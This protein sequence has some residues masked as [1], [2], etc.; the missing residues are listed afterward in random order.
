M[1]LT[2]LALLLIAAAMHAVTNT[3][4]KKSKDK[5][6]FGWWQ[7]GFFCVA[8]SP[9]LLFLK[10]VPA[11]GWTFVILSGTLEA[12]YFYSL[13]QAYT[14]G[15]LSV[16]YPIARGSAP[17]FVLIWASLFLNERPTSIGLLGIF[18]VV[19]GLYFI[20]LP[21]IQDWIRPLAGLR[22]PA[23]R[24]ALLTGLLISFYT[25]I[26]K[27]GIVYFS[28]WVY[29]YMI[30]AISWI[31]LGLQW[32]IPERRTALLAEVS[33]DRSLLPVLGASFFGTCG[34]ALVLT[35]MKLT[36]VSYVSPV[37]E[38]SVVMGTWIG[39]RFLGE[40]GGRLR[41][42]AACFVAAG[43]LLIAVAG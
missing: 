16:V 5:L 9:L 6:A 41:V 2:S 30:L 3:L 20:H 15:E 10:H 18:L 8:A 31:F 34:Y 19:A 38:I 42:V 35:A 1:L 28:P 40:T 36:P 26:D 17:L 29:L 21:R 13:S 33:L 12:I 39:V 7:M 43:V 32:L 27:K 25:A 37:R 14:R 4:M 11:I 22:T 23:V 24:W